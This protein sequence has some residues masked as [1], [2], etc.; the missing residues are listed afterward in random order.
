[1]KP[2]ISIPFAV[3]F[4]IA[5]TCCAPIAR[6]QSPVTSFSTSY[7]TAGS[8]LSNYID[9]PA[10]FSGS[11]TSCASTL[12]TYSFANGSSNELKLSGFNAAAQSFIVAPGAAATVKLRRVNNSNVTGNRNIVFM[13]TTS[14]SASNCPVLGLIGFKLPYNDIMESFL[15]N[16]IINQGTDNIFTNAGNGDKNFN[17]IERVDVLFPAGLKTATP[18]NAGFV[19]IDRGTNYAHDPFRITAV[20][21]LDANGDPASFGSVKTCT[22]GNGSNNNGSWGHPSV[23]NGNKQLATYV[24]RKDP[25]ETYLKVSAAINQELGGVFFT[26]ADL[27]VSANQTIYGY[28][29]IGPDGTANPG[30]AQLLNTANAS[31]Y[32]TGTTEAD[33][34]GLDLVSVNTVF[35]TGAAVLLPMQVVSFEGAIQNS[36]AFLQWQLNLAAGDNKIE[37]Q[38]SEDGSSFYTVYSTYAG[39]GTATMSF[40]DK[41]AAG[42]H[43]YRLKITRAL[44]GEPQ[45]SNTLPLALNTGTAFRVYPSITRRGQ[46]LQLEGLADG[47][48]TAGFCNMYGAIIKTTVYVQSGGAAL[49]P[50]PGLAPGVYLLTLDNG[51]QAP[52]SVK[53]FIH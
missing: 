52:K 2:R 16:N 39:F 26:F 38:R 24:L 33:G 28:S 27:G 29:L 18:V 5:I 40:A 9:L 34:G 3:A 45:Y 21:S 36:G 22:G 23:A 20:T 11:F 1:M 44:P 19:I 51:K 49:E 53:L 37:L 8:A 14:A 25:A 35:V 31:V 17:N 42:I 4:I 6:S 46:Q 41:P 47:W 7:T 15:D 50:P 48:Y 10:L 30:S 12:Y 13:E 43:Y 32:P